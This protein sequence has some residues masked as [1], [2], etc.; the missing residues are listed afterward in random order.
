MEPKYREGV[1]Y[2]RDAAE[3]QYST[4]QFIGLHQRA[5]A[6]AEVDDFRFF[7]PGIL[8]SFSRFDRS[9]SSEFSVEIGKPVRFIA[10]F[11]SR[12]LFRGLAAPSADDDWNK[13]LFGIEVEHWDRFCSWCNGVALAD[14]A[15]GGFLRVGVQKLHI[16]DPL[17]LDRTLILPPVP[18]MIEVAAMCVD[19]TRGCWVF[20]DEGNVLEPP[21]VKR[22][23]S[24]V[25]TVH[26][27][28]LINQT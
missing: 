27:A 4:P 7:T 22:I 2:W 10:E 28:R 23:T 20:E 17:F 13:T 14:P 19:S 6:L 18:P 11:F 24:R 8:Y 16:A 25:D 5:R 26:L 21:A 1:H 9:L 15:L 3:E 12:P